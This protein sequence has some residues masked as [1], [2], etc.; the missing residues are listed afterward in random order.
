[1]KVSNWGLGYSLVPLGNQVKQQMTDQKGTIFLWGSYGDVLS[2]AKIHSRIPSVYWTFSLL[3]RGRRL[4][5]FRELWF[6]MNVV[7]KIMVPFWVPIIIRHLI[8]RV[9]KKGP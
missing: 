2:P 1:M 9:P 4:H 8:F 5:L 3:T 6:K 7:V